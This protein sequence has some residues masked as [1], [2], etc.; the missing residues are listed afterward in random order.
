LLIEQGNELG[1]SCPSP[2]TRDRHYLEAW[3]QHCCDAIGRLRIW[4][5][6]TIREILDLVVEV[7]R[8]TI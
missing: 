5:N 4:P 7:F 1:F 6:A 8:P 2:I 3:T